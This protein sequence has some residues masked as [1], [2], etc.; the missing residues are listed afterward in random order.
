MRTRNPL[1]VFRLDASPI[2]L[3]VGAGDRLTSVAAS[4]GTVWAGTQRG[5]LF[6]YEGS[7][8]AVEEAHGTLGDGSSI[9]RIYADGRT[10][11]ALILTSSADA[12]YARAAGQLRPRT[13]PKLRGMRCTAAAWAPGNGKRSTILLGTALGSLFCFTFDD[14]NERDDNVERLWAAPGGEAVDGVRV[15]RVAGKLVAIVAT[16]SKMYAFFDQDNLHKLFAAQ[17][18]SAVQRASDIGSMKPSAVI[19]LPSELVF[20]SGSSPLSSRRFVWAGGAGVTHAQLAV[21]RR[22]GSKSSSGASVV[23]SV[24]DKATL[25]WGAL[26]DAAGSGAPLAVN[27]TTWHVLVLYPGSIYAFNHISGSL[28]QRLDVWSP[29]AELRE[30]RDVGDTDGSQTE[31]LAAPAAGMARDVASDVLW[32]FSEDGQLARVMAGDNQ[33]ADAWQA[34]TDV[35]KFDLA[36]NLAPMVAPGAVVTTRQAVLRAQAENAASGGDWEAAASLFAKTEK[37]VEEVVLAIYD[38]ALQ[39]EEASRSS[40]KEERIGAVTRAKM[41]EYI[42]EYLVRK[43]D[44][45]DNTRYTQR[46]LIA[47]VLV[48]LY[49]GRISGEVDAPKRQEIRNDFRAFLA[50]HHPDLD[51]RTA[52]DILANHACL[53]DAK[54][55]TELAGEPALALESAVQRMDIGD[56][57]NVLRVSSEKGDKDTAEKAIALL[58]HSLVQIS[59]NRVCEVVRKAQLG[60]VEHLRLLSSL[61]RTARTTVDGEKRKE[62]YEAAVAYVDK[63]LQSEE[64]GSFSWGEIVKFLFAL[65]AEHQEEEE[66]ERSVEKIL[67]PLPDDVRTSK[68]GRNC[69]TCALRATLSSRLMRPAVSLY[70]LLGQT[71]AAVKLAIR[72]APELAEKTLAAEGGHLTKAKQRV[73]WKEIAAQSKEAVAVSERSLGALAVHDVLDGM[74][75]FE[76][77]SAQVKRAVVKELGEHR[78]VAS[79]SKMEA[80]KAVEASERLRKDVKRA[81]KWRAARTTNAVLSC[82]H[83]N[84]TK[85]CGRCGDSL[86]DE[87]D[88]PFDEDPALDLPL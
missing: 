17:T 62:S 77:A 29:A 72:D 86:I 23:A 21:R 34:A 68:I 7:T 10:R 44:Q 6:R 26:K 87:L 79:E 33:H 25:T 3:R 8:G 39:D 51:V 63:A 4:H 41:I 49:A 42:I 78:R 24:V 54:I 61:A 60:K 71:E 82:G 84:E 1:T 43:L 31:F 14:Y 73:L 45:I 69:L 40:N 22:R 85:Q 16:R 13:V 15:E 28:T 64:A 18:V 58:T 27:L 53:E 50:D 32:V 2:R 57:L 36:M 35:G 56:A 37:P 46:T 70:V 47:T 48:Q 81:K 11:A 67:K 74:E 65:H 5:R 80:Q 75:G 19:P 76:T 83:V 55:L 59:P 52:L 9:A 38:A 20:M 66:A 30:G 88:S 12:F